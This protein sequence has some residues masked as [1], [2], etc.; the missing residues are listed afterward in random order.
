M[1]SNPKI[2]S[3]ASFL[4]RLGERERYEAPPRSRGKEKLAGMLQLLERLGHPERRLKVVHVAGTNG[5]GMTAAMVAR[6]LGAS[7]ARVGLYTSPHLTDIRERI[8][9]E[10]RPI[11]KEAFQLAGGRVLDVAEEMG[12]EPYLSYFDLLTAMG[13]LAIADAGMDWSVLETGLGGYSDATNTCE[14]S[15][16][17]ITPIGL[18]HM[19]VLGGT[20]REIAEQ[21]LG[22]VR[23]GIP[24]CLAPQEEELAEWMEQRVRDH[25]SDPVRVTPLAWEHPA[26]SPGRLRIWPDG[27]TDA[28][29]EIDARRAP[30]PRLNC[31][32]TALAA[33]S[34]LLGPA[35][36][37][38]LGSRLHTA[39]HT[40]VPGRLDFREQLAIRNHQGAPFASALLD[41]GH[42]LPALRML[43][44]QMKVWGFEDYSLIF[45]MQADK[46]LPLLHEPLGRLL[47]GARRIITLAPRTPRAPTTEALHRY[48]EEIMGSRPGAEMLLAR[49]TPREALLE[50]AQWPASPLL[51]A[52]SFWMLGDVM[53]ELELA[54]LEFAT[55]AG[56]D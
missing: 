31:A 2:D 17:I 42:N 36:G 8:M 18:D 30:P 40:P 28:A 5:K 14:K 46:L 4:A 22:I 37:E 25:G 7:G 9:L 11:G 33:A 50:A 6:L 3:Y 12:P 53:A 45:A 56:N 48:I 13:M 44:E 16:A 34:V 41:G 15:L 43:V 39:L 19:T 38:Q 52:G 51:V 32:A 29:V 24:T 47:A 55:V 20:L 27:D 23:P 1:A 10:D 35:R 49:D 54:G 21:K 26:Q